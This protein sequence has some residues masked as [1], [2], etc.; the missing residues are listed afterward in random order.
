MAQ[1]M[2]VTAK[3]RLGE[4]PVSATSE[5]SIPLLRA[6]NVAVTGWELL[7]TVVIPEKVRGVNEIWAPAP[8]V[9]AS[10]PDTTADHRFPASTMLEPI[11]PHAPVYLEGGKLSTACH[12]IGGARGAVHG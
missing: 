8:A 6:V 11:V 10:R 3:S 1:V 5:V 12:S 2:G 7:P 9:S 4:P